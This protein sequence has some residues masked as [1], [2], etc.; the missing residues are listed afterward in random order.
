MIFLKEIAYV[1]QSNLMKPSK[2]N[3]F[4]NY[5]QIDHKKMKFKD[6]LINYIF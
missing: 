3:I 2:K 1:I 4:V 5:L 6:K